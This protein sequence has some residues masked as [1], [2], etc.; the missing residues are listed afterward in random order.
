MRTN[1]NFHQIGLKRFQGITAIGFIIT[2]VLMLFLAGSNYYNISSMNQLMNKILNENNRKTELIGELRYIAR[3]RL[4][5]LFQIAEERDEIDQDSLIIAHSNL[6]GKFI[7]YREE[8]T[9]LID[10]PEEETIDQRLDESLIKAQPAHKQVLNFINLVDDAT[11]SKKLIRA[12]QAQQKVIQE[13]EALMKIQKKHNNDLNQEI[14]FYIENSYLWPGVISSFVI[15]VGIIISFLVFRFVTHQHEYVRGMNDE[16]M[17][18]NQRFVEVTLEAEKANRT[19]MDFIANMSHELRTP[20]TSIK[21]ALG[22]LGSGMI[23]DIPDDAMELVNIADSN[24]DRLMGLITDV[25]DFS[26][27][28]SGDLELVIEDVALKQEISRF[29]APYQVKGQAKNIDVKTHFDSDLPESVRA[30]I[31]HIKQIL[32]QLLNN[33]LK[34]TEQGVIELTIGLTDNHQNLSFSVK[35]TGIG[36]SEEKISDLFESFVQGDGSSTR[37]YGGTGLGLAICQRLVEALN[38]EIG[39]HTNL[40]EGSTFYFSI[41]VQNQ[42]KV[43]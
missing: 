41:P 34:F 3:E 4:L 26:K 22:M 23:G 39:V 13:L 6:A 42:Q 9:Q 16:L 29:I 38:G 15:V 17:N 35:D 21:G 7:E 5:Q 24:S 27:I 10:T 14:T 11:L 40:G 30:D 19:K 2:L 32:R 8:L 18:S 37:K 12:S 31:Q 28:E 25:L 43:A 20:M 33:S 1:D 36:V